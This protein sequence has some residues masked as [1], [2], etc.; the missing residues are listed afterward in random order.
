MLMNILKRACIGMYFYLLAS[1]IESI[2]D[3]DGVNA[4]VDEVFGLLEQSS[5]EH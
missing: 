3:F 4:L 1:Q 5:R 2:G